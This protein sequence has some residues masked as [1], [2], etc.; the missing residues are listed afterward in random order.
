MNQRDGSVATY[1][2][3]RNE[4]YSP[5]IEH[6]EADVILTFELPESGRYLP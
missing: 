5:V 6:G 3:Y 1:V 4:V 2:R